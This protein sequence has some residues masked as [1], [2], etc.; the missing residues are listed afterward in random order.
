MDALNQILLSNDH[1]ALNDA[2]KSH[3]HNQIG[4][5]DVTAKLIEELE[6]TELV[7]S[8]DIARNTAHK[9]GLAYDLVLVEANDM[10]GRGS[11]INEFFLGGKCL[12]TVN[13]S[14][15]ET[16]SISQQI[17]ISQ[18]LSQNTD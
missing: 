5:D 10:R 6:H 7:S 14:L 11:V 16:A 8:K 12:N 4:V 17:F 1:V 2:I 18:H 3:Q 13:D 15:R 9:V